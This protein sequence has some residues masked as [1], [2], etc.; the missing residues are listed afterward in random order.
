MEDIIQ[1]S[2]K[3]NVIVLKMSENKS[4]FVKVE[5]YTLYFTLLILATILTFANLFLGKNADNMQTNLM[6]RNFICLV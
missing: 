4:V 5:A 2:F 6:N 3:I 1:Q